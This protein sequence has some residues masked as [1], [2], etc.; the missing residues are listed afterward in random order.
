MSVKSILAMTAKFKKHV[1]PSYTMIFDFLMLY[2]TSKHNSTASSDD[3][4]STCH[5]F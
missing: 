4:Y 3:T 5:T 1:Q 2:E